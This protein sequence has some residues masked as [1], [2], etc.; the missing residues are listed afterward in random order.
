MEA[1]KSTV[2]KNL[3]AVVA[4]YETCCNKSVKIY[5]CKGAL[6]SELLKD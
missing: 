3:N 2:A 6:C 1:T 4:R 5:L